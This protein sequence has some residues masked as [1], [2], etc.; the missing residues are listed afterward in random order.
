MSPTNAIGP[1]QATHAATASEPAAEHEQAQPWHVNAARVRELLA[2][3]E[4]LQRAREQEQ[5]NP[6]GNDD[7]EQDENARVADLLAGAR[8][9]SARRR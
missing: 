5:H 9:T 3:R 1:H 6:D 2:E 8:A 7:R 4:G